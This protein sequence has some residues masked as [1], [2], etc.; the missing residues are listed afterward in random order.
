MSLI[1]KLWRELKTRGVV[2]AAVAYAVAGFIVLLAVGLISQFLIFPPWLDRLLTRTVIIGLPITIAAAWFVDLRRD[3][4]PVGGRDLN[5]ISEEERA[6]ATSLWKTT[7]VVLSILALTF[8]VGALHTTRDEEPQ[9]AAARVVIMPFENRTGD[10]TLNSIGGV[11][12]DW[13]TQRLMQTRGV[14][15]VPYSSVI[16]YVTAAPLAPGLPDNGAPELARGVGAAYVVWGAYHVTGDS[17]TYSADMM[18]VRTGERVREIRFARTPLNDPLRG[19][20]VFRENVAY[21]VTRQL[22][23]G[24]STWPLAIPRP[25]SAAAHTA[26]TRG[27]TVM[28]RNADSAAILF[29]QAYN[30]DTSFVQARVWQAR[31]LMDAHNVAA[32]DTVAQH[33]NDRRSRLTMYE[34]A[35]LDHVIHRTQGDLDLRYSSAELMT[36]LAPAS[37]DAIRLLAIDALAVN[38]PREARTLLLSVGPDKGWMRGWAGYYENLTIAQHLVRNYREELRLAE[39][40]IFR[41]PGHPWIRA[42]QCRALAALERNAEATRIMRHVDDRAAVMYCANELE[43]HVGYPAAVRVASLPGGATPAQPDVRT[44]MRAFGDALSEGMPYAEA[45]AVMPHADYQLRA[46]RA[47]AAFQRVIQPGG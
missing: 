13:I 32:A 26:F 35:H 20:N 24:L 40:A 8:F 16:A 5:E 41:F 46:L 11:T 42:A 36:V 10:S 21:S 2:T 30:L 25:P 47:L 14:E 19:I 4:R 9:L 27:V 15:V 22:R 34:R 31:A 39:E 28:T 45:R 6:R 17:L 7:G 33:A 1:R 44:L 12:A 38:H 29:G 43:A 37:D 18:D 3:I 23:V